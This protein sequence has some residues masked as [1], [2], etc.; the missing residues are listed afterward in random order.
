MQPQVL[1]QLNLR[2]EML[3]SAAFGDSC[4]RDDHQRPGGSEVP[5]VPDSTMCKPARGSSAAVVEESNGSEESE[6]LLLM[7]ALGEDDLVN[8]AQ[9]SEPSLGLG[10]GG[11]RDRGAEDVSEAGQ[12]EVSGRGSGGGEGRPS[13]GTSASTS[14]EVTG[15]ERQKGKPR[16]SQRYFREILGEFKRG[17]GHSLCDGFI[18]TCIGLF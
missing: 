1:A 16:S 5:S 3:E 2:L 10:A 4:G 12:S 15:G 13:D 14:A 9:D 7:A 8:P 6:V 18:D 17:E 11:A